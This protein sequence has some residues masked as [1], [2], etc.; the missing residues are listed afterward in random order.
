M[1]WNFLIWFRTHFSMAFSGIIF[2]VIV[3]HFSICH[4][5]DI[6]PNKYI[7]NVNKN[8]LCKPNTICVRGCDNNQNDCVCSENNILNC[9][10]IFFLDFCCCHDR[11]VLFFG[12]GENG[13]MFIERKEEIV[14]FIYVLQMFWNGGKFEIICKLLFLHFFSFT[15]IFW[16]SIKCH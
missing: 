5:I 10:T 11:D 16:T 7:L 9:W 1:R 4:E 6:L 12:I 14:W 15:I 8:K 2:N 3:S 13:Q